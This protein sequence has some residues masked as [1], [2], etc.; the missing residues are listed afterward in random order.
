MWGGLWQEG[1]QSERPS[2][3]GSCVHNLGFS[4]QFWWPLQASS[5]KNC[6]THEKLQAFL[7]FSSLHSKWTTLFPF[8]DDL[9]YVLFLWVHSRNLL[10]NRGLLGS[11][12]TTHLGAPGWLSPLS[13]WLWLRSWSFSLWVRAPCRALC[14]WQLRARSLLQSLCFPLSL[15][16]PHSCSVSLCQK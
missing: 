1:T 4:F 2:Q 5:P 13:A 12:R 6:A 14:C 16:L 7:S 11:I 3:N 10:L 15:P 9:P 8:V